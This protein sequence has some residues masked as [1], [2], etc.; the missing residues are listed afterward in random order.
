MRFASPKRTGERVRSAHRLVGGG[1]SRLIP[2]EWPPE[3][4]PQVSGRAWGAI[5]RAF[6]QISTHAGPKAAIEGYTRLYHTIGPIAVNGTLFAG[7]L[8]CD[9]VKDLAPVS[10]VGKVPHILTAHPGL[11]YRNMR[12][13]IAAARKDPGKIR[14][15]TAGPGT[16]QHLSVELLN[17][18]VGIQT[19]GIP[20]Q[21]SAQM[22]TD[23]IGGQFDVMFHNAPE[24]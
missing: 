13:L 22:T 16:T 8:P 10:L 7:E 1:C 23:A 15:A 3:A 14:Y 20:Y 4:T 24:D 17:T 11:P 21:S 5:R 9:P 19:T 12:D 6:P 2:G 18:L